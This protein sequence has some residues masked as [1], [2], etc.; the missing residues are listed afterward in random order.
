MSSNEPQPPLSIV[1]PCY[2][3]EE[4][5]HSLVQ[6]LGRVAAEMPGIEVLLV[7][8]G[9]NDRTADA[10]AS[11]VDSTRPWLRSVNVTVNKGYGY[12]VMQGV[13]A[14]RGDVIAWT[15]ADM[16][17]NPIDVLSAYAVFIMSGQEKRIVKGKRANRGLVD[18]FFTAGMSIFATIALGMPLNDINAQP[19]LFDRSFLS[20]LDDYPHDFS[21]DLFLLLQAKQNGYAVLTTPVIFAERLRGEAKG[22]G[23]FKGKMRL[24]ERTV[25][26]IL[27][28]RNKRG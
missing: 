13:L 27:H 28:T 24:I 10:L 17:T 20:L 1:I 19:K 21:L 3:E 26:Y 11:L 25:R 8:N 2:N 18:T 22:G 23:T 7:N 14:A 16:Q 9:S 6:S 5:L 4:N 15:H 12:G